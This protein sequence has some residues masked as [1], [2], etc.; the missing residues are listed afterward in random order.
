MPREPFCQIATKAARPT[1]IDKP[2]AAQRA[3]KRRQRR[4]HFE[5]AEAD[6]QDRDQHRDHGKYRKVA[7]P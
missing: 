3:E 7:R 5:E 2:G 1:R 6:D 4:F